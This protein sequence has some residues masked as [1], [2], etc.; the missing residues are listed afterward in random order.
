MKITVVFNNVPH[1]ERLETC[2]GFSACIEGLEKKILFDTGGDENILLANMEK[3]GI[4]PGSIDIVVLSHAHYD[5]TGGLEGFLKK[6]KHCTVYA[7][8]A[9]IVPA[10][11]PMKICEDAW[12]SGLLG[13]GIKEQALAV[14]SE[15]GLVVLTG[16]A[17]P[18]IVK[19]AAHVKN[20]LKKN[21]YL[22]MGGFH[23]EFIP[24]FMVKRVISNLRKLGVGKVA[25]S[26]CTGEK[27]IELFKS[28]W[29]ENFIDLGCGALYIF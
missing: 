18:G 8:D 11:E 27:A 21:I 24:G 7:P 6:N 20:A 13:A 5:H 3:L 12:I 19:I 28:A 14:D 2:W 16:C 9:K 29:G 1:D 15:K 25:P 4:D 17:H 23:L 26:H 10:N 22:L